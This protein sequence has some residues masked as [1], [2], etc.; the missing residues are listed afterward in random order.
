MSDGN[1]LPSSYIEA[2]RMEQTH[3]W[4]AVV[5]FN[6]S[7][8]VVGGPGRIL[9]A[10]DAVATVVFARGEMEKRKWQSA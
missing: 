9:S 7:V 3:D 1:S 5:P 10:E 8:A 6:A 2:L 4:A